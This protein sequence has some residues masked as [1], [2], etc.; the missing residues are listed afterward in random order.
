MISPINKT[1]PIPKYYQ[2]YSMLHDLIKAGEIPPGTALPPT[3]ELIERFGVS[4]I[5]L[6]KA[7][8]MLDAEGIIERHQ[9]KGTYACDITSRESIIIG[10]LNDLSLDTRRF[11]RQY[12]WQAIM[13]GVQ[14][15]TSDH[16]YA[17]NL[18]SPQS[19][20]DSSDVTAQINGLIFHPWF[21]NK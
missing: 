5:T 16:K 7:M 21:R 13:D 10:L 4:R 18:I 1:S 9:G 15:V 17:L 11:D 20:A 6:T 3:S 19:H 2:V 14:Q 12:L 8:D